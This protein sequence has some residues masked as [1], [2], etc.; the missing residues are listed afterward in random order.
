MLTNSESLI[1]N[2]NILQ[3][4]YLCNSDHYTISF[5]VKT[6]VKHK[7][8]PKRKI[9]NFKKANWDG[10]NH[11]LSHIQW[12]AYIDCTEPEIAWTN[13]KN[14]LF[15][16]I[17]KHIPTITIKS[18]F[19]MP[20]F[21]S[22]CYEAYRDKQRAHKKSKQDKNQKTE[23]IFKSKRRFFKNLCS[24]KMRDNLYNEEDPELI[25]KKFYSH[26]KSSSKSN[27]LPDCMNLNGCFRNKSIDKAELFNRY[28]SEQFSSPSNYNI[29]IDWSNDSSFNIDFCHRKIRKLLLKINPNKA[30][31]PD[32]IHGRVLKN[33]A[34][35]LAYPLSLMFKLSYNLGSLPREWKL[36]NVVP[37]HKKGSKDN[38]ENY[39]PISLTSLVMKTFEK[40]LK[41]E[42]LSRT[43]H[44]LD[45][46]Q[47]GFLSKKSCATNLIG[48]SENIVMSINDCH[49]MCIDVIY[50]DFSKAFDSVN[51]DII[52]HKLKH[53][54]KLDGRLL[55]FIKNYLSDREQ[56]VVI[57]GIKSSLTP[58]HS[59][60][61]Q[62]SIIGP[63]LFVLFIND[64]PQG[65][66][67]KSNIALYADDTKLWRSIKSDHDHLQLQKDIAYLHSWSLHN[68][69]NFNLQKCKV[70]AIKNKPSPLAM[71]PFV[72]YHYYLAENL[73]EYAD[74]EKDLGVYIN[75]DFN[76]TEHCNSILSK[77]NQQYGLLKRTCNFVNDTRRRRVLY[78]TLARSQFNHCST[79]WRPTEITNKT[80]VEKF[81]N[82]QKKCIKWILCEEEYSYH[83]HKTYIRKCQ[84]AN[85]LPLL[86]IFKTN[87]MVMFHQIVYGLIP[88]SMPDYL[89]LY[90]GTSGLRIT[91]LDQLSYV[92]NIQHNT[93][94]IN[95]LNK[96][97]FFRSHTIWNSLPIDIR[98]E[99]NPEKFKTE[100]ENHFWEL[101]LQD[102]NE[103]E[104]DSLLTSSGD[105]YD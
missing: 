76:F 64:L 23:L 29:D 10:L 50:F 95:N 97:F 15:M 53:I 70:V 62:G 99:K 26:V 55:K 85:V 31:G 71:L 56:C 21:D 47:H 92:S 33:C 30:C 65:I 24:K 73:L 86:Y 105:E 18:N 94:S 38:I 17:K 37:V 82:F 77:A 51:H 79:I 11:D 78:L 6:N 100:L 43:S 27:R 35:S 84:Q 60:V 20:W 98:K 61:P 42:I 59:G 91:H 57:D 14:I 89:T 87:D 66:D 7:K 41:Q 32:E 88:L 5:E 90:D 102:T 19:S 13:F 9:L 52:L 2:I 72:A 12:N 68:K 1:S 25:T 49:T 75:K 83:S 101:A 16:Y 74:S 44:L 4:K 28:F 8:V 93:T 36:A 67:D 80:L 58:V 22:E 46:C 48:F 39:R 81:E 54:Y 104:E 103:S 96:S 3:N 63:I 45:E 69:I 34:V 40:I